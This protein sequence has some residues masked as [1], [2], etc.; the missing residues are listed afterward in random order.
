[1][2]LDLD[3]D[4]SVWL[5][6]LTTCSACWRQCAVRAVG[7]AMRRTWWPDRLTEA[8]GSQHIH[9]MANLISLAESSAQLAV[10]CVVPTN[11]LTEGE[12]AAALSSFPGTCPSPCP[13][14]WSGCASCVPLSCPCGCGGGRLPSPAP[15]WHA[16]A[17]AACHPLAARG[18]RTCRP[19][20]P[21]CQP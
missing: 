3:T 2:Q 1:M 9:S 5:P 10:P 16:C 7:G 20:P 18:I 6:T 21:L 13:W 8:D 12:E 14:I 17:T 19:H 4:S 15:C 11:S